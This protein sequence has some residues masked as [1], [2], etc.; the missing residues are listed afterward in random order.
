MRTLQDV[1][2]QTEKQSLKDKI[3]NLPTAK[4]AVIVVGIVGL[5]YLAYKKFFVKKSIE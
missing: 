3:A 4:K 1:Q 2:N 5:T